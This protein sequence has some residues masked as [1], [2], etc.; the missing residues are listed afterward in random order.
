MIP[1]SVWPEHI[2]DALK[3]KRFAQVLDWIETENPCDA[4]LL[5]ASVY[6]WWGKPMDA[7]DVLT[8]A[9][10]N[11]PGK[12]HLPYLWYRGLMYVQ[13]SM[14]AWAEQ[15]FDVFIVKSPAHPDLAKLARAYAR[16]LLGDVHGALEDINGLP[17]GT[18]LVFDRVV[19]TKWIID[20]A[21]A[22]LKR[23]VLKESNAGN[24]MI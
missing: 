12:E 1:T 4:G 7:V 21:T 23:T 11:L 6:E 22:A 20:Y 10:K 13:A 5:K 19:T 17:L 24:A 2:R 8:R 14:P 15:D 16:V 18:T 9:L 3:E